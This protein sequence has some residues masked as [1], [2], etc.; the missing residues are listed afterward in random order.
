[1]FPKQDLKNAARKEE[2]AVVD[3]RDTGGVVL[4]EVDEET[5]GEVG[6]KSRGRDTQ[7]DIRK[8]T[9][10]AQTS[11]PVPFFIPGTFSFEVGI[12][13]LHQSI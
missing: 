8:G 3:N 7:F 6:N 1:M 11:K 4:A 13:F 10:F 2:E 9:G 5:K 12:V